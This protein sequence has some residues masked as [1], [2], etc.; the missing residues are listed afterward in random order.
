[1]RGFSSDFTCVT[2]ADLLTA[3]VTWRRPEVSHQ[4]Q[5]YTELLLHSFRLS[6][7]YP[8]PQLRI[9]PL[10]RQG[11]SPQYRED[12]RSP[13]TMDYDSD[14]SIVSRKVS[15]TYNVY[16]GAS[17]TTQNRLEVCHSFAC[18]LLYD[19]L[20]HIRGAFYCIYAVLYIVHY[21]MDYSLLL[22][23]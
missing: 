22:G 16:R 7:V 19:S 15:R 3:R 1:M 17:P 2:L 12:T 23:C 6:W 21:C 8:R 10:L 18:S 11:L 9:L 5:R 4:K 20:M 13:A 14:V